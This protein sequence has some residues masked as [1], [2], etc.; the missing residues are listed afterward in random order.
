MKKLLLSLTLLVSILSVSKASEKGDLVIQP[1]LM[2]GAYGPVDRYS[3]GN[4]GGVMLNVDYAVIDYLSVGGYVGFS[5]ADTYNSI[6]VGARGVFHWWQLIDDKGSRDLK[7]DKFDL[8]MPFFVGLRFVNGK[9]GTL[10]DNDFFP[11]IGLGARYYFNDKIGLAF[12]FG[13]LEMSSAKL[14]VSIKL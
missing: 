13:G 4:W 14:G 10:T 8:Y 12:E 11:G 9:D 6:G 3:N 2:L 1:S 7:S 5:G